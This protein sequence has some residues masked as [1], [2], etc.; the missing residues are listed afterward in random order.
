MPK[1][2][3][4]NKTQAR[5]NKRGLCIIC[6]NI[7]S[8]DININDNASSSIDSNFNNILE[9]KES[10]DH[11]PIND[12]KII[13]LFKD[14]MIKEKTW[15]DE[16]Q[17]LL[18]EQIEFLKSELIV[19]N[20]LI[21]SLLV[22][23]FNRSPESK[24]DATVSVN[25]STSLRNTNLSEPLNVI[26]SD[27]LDNPNARNLKEHCDNKSDFGDKFI[28]D[29]VIFNSSI[30]H[31][32]KYASLMNDNDSHDETELVTE[33]INVKY[34]APTKIYN[35]DDKK[36]SS[37][38]INQFPEN[39][40][41]VFRQPNIIPGNAS[42]SNM[43][44]QGRKILI[45]SDSI[46]GRIQMKKLNNDIKYGKAYRKY[47]PG[48]TPTEM[49][50]YSLPTLEKDQPDVVVI[51]TGTNSLSNNNIHDIGN[52]ILN[53]VKIC[54]NHGV[55]DVIV[56]GI[57]FRYHYLTKLR[58]LNTFLESQKLNYDFKFVNNEN[59]IG[60]DIGKDKLHLN[61]DGIV[62]IAN[63]ITDAINTLHS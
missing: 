48:A 13:D 36:R 63:N 57:T 12:R 23:L 15:N 5:F 49:L 8:K 27:T 40:Q 6:K 16:M 54:R 38:V 1:C 53:L 25:A 9:T 42:Y 3:N 32:N 7:N 51:H 59:I 30:I 22:E 62:K 45:L 58:E 56:S 31:P 28:N 11:D 35:F 43:T 44:S 20:T 52:E 60:K 19:K 14:N 4:C 39:D 10:N 26:S 47:F 24:N 46:L 41:K 29:S 18:K 34:N 50:H 55:N 61:Y 21:E 33:D 37:I 17:N 2:S